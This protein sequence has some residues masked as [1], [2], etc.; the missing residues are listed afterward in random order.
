MNKK[1]QLAA[2]FP[3]DINNDNS[4]SASIEIPL[5][6]PKHRR[7]NRKQQ[8]EVIITKH[9]KT[10]SGDEKPMTEQQPLRPVK[11][12]R[13]KERTAIPQMPKPIV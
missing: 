3:L 11:L 12:S 7:T 9:E 1:S 2:I 4:S 10:N 8:A 5:P 13:K 6:Q